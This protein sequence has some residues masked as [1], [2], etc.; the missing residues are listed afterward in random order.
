M[1]HKYFGRILEGKRALIT[2][3][4]KGLGL[5]M[6]HRF[7]ECGAKVAICCAPNE[8]ITEAVATLK[9]LDPSYEILGFNPCLTD[10]AAL[11]QV[12][13]T[14][15]STWGGLDILINNAGL[16]PAKPFEEYPQ[17]M[18]KKVFDV[19]VTGLFV[20]SKKAAQLMKKQN[21]GAIVNTSSM[22]GI[23]GAMRNIG[24]TASK[25]AVEGM[26][27]GM[28]RELGQYGIRVNGVAPACM[29]RTDVYGNPIERDAE[30]MKE[31]A[32]S[33]D[34]AAIKKASDIA[35]KFAPLGKFESH[36]DE[37]INAFIFLASDAA[38]FISGQTIAVSGAC[39]W[40]AASPLSSLE[41]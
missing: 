8:D 35:L 16:Y 36:P 27:L 37:E 23:D 38:A 10:E 20:I 25:F 13:E 5:L 28:A 24:Y 21:K 22:A 1:S 29:T 30:N 39:I 41:I 14:I 6:A 15:E 11:D 26:T 32:G 40:P 2:G 34:Y 3:S 33:F 17:E 19:N 4:N 31:S 9:S 7:L 18:F 12:M